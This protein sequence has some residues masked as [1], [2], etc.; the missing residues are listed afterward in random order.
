MALEEAIGDGLLHTN[1]AAGNKIPLKKTV[2]KA[3]KV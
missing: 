1:V 3:V 2:E